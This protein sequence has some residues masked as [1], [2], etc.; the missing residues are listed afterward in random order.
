MEIRGTRQNVAPPGKQNSVKRISVPGGPHKC[1]HHVCHL[2]CLKPPES[3]VALN[4]AF[5]QHSLTGPTPCPRLEW[6]IREGRTS[7]SAPGIWAPRTEQGAAQKLTASPPQIVRS[8]L[9]RQFCLQSEDSHWESA[10]HRGPPHCSGSSLHQ[11]RLVIS[12][13]SQCRL[14]STSGGACL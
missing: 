8:E 10:V 12:P 7:V 11:W 9:Q 5:C 14:L 6:M 4:I 3:S 1:C 13:G 2:L